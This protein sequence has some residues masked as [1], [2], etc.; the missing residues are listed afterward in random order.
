MKYRHN[1]SKNVNHDNILFTLKNMD[2]RWKNQSEVI[3]LAVLIQ[4]C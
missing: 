2:E 1:P 4:A 3:A